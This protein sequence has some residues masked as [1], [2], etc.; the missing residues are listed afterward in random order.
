MTLG[1]LVPEIRYPSPVRCHLPVRYHI[2]CAPHAMIVS[3]LA[4]KDT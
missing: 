1:R 2:L 4:F 3:M